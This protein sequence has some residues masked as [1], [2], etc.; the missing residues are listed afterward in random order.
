MYDSISLVLVLRTGRVLRWRPG[1]ARSSTRFEK[2]AGG[3]SHLEGEVHEFRDDAVAA[4][5]VLVRVLVSA[6]RGIEVCV[7]VCVCVIS[8]S[9]TLRLEDSLWHC[10]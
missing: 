6:S 2:V 7:C 8:V 10:F 3:A 1:V 5:P 9:D 4:V